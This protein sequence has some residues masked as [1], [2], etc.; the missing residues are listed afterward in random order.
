MRS[1]CVFHRVRREEKYALY[2]RNSRS[3]KEFIT[4]AIYVTLN[5]A[6]S[7]LKGEFLR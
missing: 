6:T 2:Q 3:L 1:D 5:I 7:A 4:G